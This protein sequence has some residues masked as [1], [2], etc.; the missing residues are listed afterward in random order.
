MVMGI[1]NQAE[2]EKPRK[3]VI[4]LST[5]KEAILSSSCSSFP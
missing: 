4:V 5:C 2:E 3:R 1:I